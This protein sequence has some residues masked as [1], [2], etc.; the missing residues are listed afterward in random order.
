MWDFINNQGG[1]GRTTARG[2]TAVTLLCLISFS[3]AQAQTA[4]PTPDRL[5]APPTVPAPTQADDGAQLYWLHCQPCHG[6]VGQGLT[7]APD[8]DWRAQYPP[9]DQYCWES[10]CHGARPYEEGFTIPRQIPPVIGE[11]SLQRF[12]TLAEAYTFIRAAMPLQAPN[13][14]TAAEYLAITAF[15]AQAHNAGNG[16]QLTEDT[17]GTI[18]LSTVYNQPALTPTPTPPPQEEKPMAHEPTPLPA[19]GWLVGGVFVV[20]VILGGVLWRRHGR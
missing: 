5:A 13:S 12:A 11:G 20:M 4:V 17:L 15:L 14:L 1:I 9:E 19:I 8:D 18:P 10:G 2:L 7:D 16:Q 6:D 3:L